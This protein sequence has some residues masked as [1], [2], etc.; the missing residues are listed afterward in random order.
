MTDKRSSVSTSGERDK[1]VVPGAGPPDDNVISAPA[2]DSA[3]HPAGRS[4]AAPADTAPPVFASVAA[5]APMTLRPRVGD[6]RPGI[7]LVLGETLRRDPLG[8]TYSAREVTGSREV[9]ITLYHA[10]AASTQAAVDRFQDAILMAAVDH[11]SILSAERVGR[12][13][14]QVAVTRRLVYAPTLGEA[15]PRGMQCEFERAV[16]VLR[17]IADALDAAH[18]LG[19][20]HGD[21]RPEAILLTKSA[22]PLLVGCGVA[23][24]LDLS[25]VLTATL[26]RRT[27]WGWGWLEAASPYLAPERWRG[28]PP[29]ARSDQY[30][31]AIIAFRLLAGEL[32]FAAEHVAQ[33]AELHR[34][35]V[36]PRA[37]AS[38]PELPPAADVAITR[39]LAKVAADR[40][41]TA[42]GFVDALSGQQSRS[43]P[44]VT[45]PARLGLT[46]GSLERP[47]W[48]PPVAA[49][50]TAVLLAVTA[51]IVFVLR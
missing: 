1:A 39:A 34:I 10:A 26:E 22:G 35:A 42:G 6:L 11:P 9:A 24:G 16:D 45:D 25:S 51:I 3:G 30:A 32:P 19:I 21:L 37:S 41:T 43:Q 18:G 29:D 31:L 14:T 36:I 50:I 20:I 46:V 23:D 33:L 15:F 7:D 49:L 27:E 12:W 4:G 38:R 48:R 2:Q 17:P 28:A 5:K 40:F 13:G 47:V 8:V 44:I